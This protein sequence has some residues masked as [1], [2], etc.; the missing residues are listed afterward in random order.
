MCHRLLLYVDKKHSL[1]IWIKL[2]GIFHI[3]FCSPWPWVQ[4]V[5]TIFP[6]CCFVVQRHLACLCLF[7]WCT[8]DL[9]KQ[10]LDAQTIQ[11]STGS[12]STSWMCTAKWNLGNQMAT[13]VPFCR[14]LTDIPTAFRWDSYFTQ[15]QGLTG[16]RIWGPVQTPQGIQACMFFLSTGQPKLWPHIIL[17]LVWNSAIERWFMRRNCQVFS[18]NWMEKKFFIGGKKRPQT[19]TQKTH[20]M[21]FLSLAWGSTFIT[22]LTWLA[23][24]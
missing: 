23:R 1:Y 16:C 3:V 12:C 18:W 15:P 20:R 13:T 7:C 14:V 21:K 5:H 22:S 8:V 11:S 19:C 24:G 2:M 10:E 9:G 17:L 4:S 6:Q